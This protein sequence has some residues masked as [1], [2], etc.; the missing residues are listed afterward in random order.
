[1]DTDVECPRCHRISF[2][3]E[4]HHSCTECHWTIRPSH[5]EKP[6]GYDVLV[7]VRATNCTTATEVRHYKG[8]ETTARRRARLFPNFVRV[9]AV[10]PLSK[11][12]WLSAYGEG[13]M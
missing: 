7:E 4:K 11:A 1:M 10:D 3:W 9:L 13:R 2:S 8:N 12:T 5:V 6:Y